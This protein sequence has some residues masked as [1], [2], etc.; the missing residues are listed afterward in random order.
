MNCATPQTNR[1]GRDAEKHASKVVFAHRLNKRPSVKIEATITNK[2]ELCVHSVFE[3]S[4]SELLKCNVISDPVQVLGA[5]IF[6]FQV[7]DPAYKQSQRHPG[8]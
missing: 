7:R 8:L 1:T 4:N 6:M 5:I 2:I 3:H